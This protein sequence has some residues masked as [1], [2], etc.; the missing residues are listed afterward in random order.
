MNI[1]I[2]KC[3]AGD[4][5]FLAQSILVAGRAH[6][7]KG[8]WEFVLGTPEK[9]CLRF[10]EQ[11]V[12]TE[13]PHLFHYSCSFIAEDNCTNPLGS[14]GGYD[15][16]KRG[17]QALQQAFPEVYKKLHLPQEAFHGANERASK[18]LSCLPKERENAW[19][20]DSVA[21]M[22][23]Y[24]GKGVA[25]RL[26]Q[27]VMAEGK[28]LGYPIVQVNMYIGNESALRLYQKLGFTVTEE[29]RDPYFEKKIGSPGMLCL[30]RKLQ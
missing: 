6:V 11:L 29:T 19:V 13:V 17:Y 3:R 27:A 9:E 7:K 4:A 15:P 25:E 20:V 2:R 22:P 5:A 10:L 28:K 18:I 26:L 1:L 21:T 30:A 12:I 8:I 23:E 16:K 14:L 24:R